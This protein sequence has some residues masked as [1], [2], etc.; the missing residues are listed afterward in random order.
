MDGQFQI[1]S[2]RVNGVVRLTLTGELDLAE[3]DAAYEALLDYIGKAGASIEF[4]FSGLA[5]VDSSGLR[6]L[7]NACRA[8]AESGVPFVVVDASE[9]LRR[10]AQLTGV[11]HVLGLN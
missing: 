8:A 5:F 4:D 7:V 6:T 1:E 10:V 9:A 3:A 2:A 11:E